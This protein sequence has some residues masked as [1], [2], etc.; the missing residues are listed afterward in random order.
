MAGAA[1]WPTS[2]TSDSTTQAPSQGGVRPPPLRTYSE[3]VASET[4]NTSDANGHFRR[5]STH[6]HLDLGSSLAGVATGAHTSKLTTV[7]ELRQ[8]PRQTRLGLGQPLSPPMTPQKDVLGGENDVQAATEEDPDILP[9][10]FSRIDYELDRARAI[11]QGLWSTVYYAQPV[12][13]TSSQP[14]QDVPSPPLSPQWTV[15]LPSVSLYAIKIA[16]RADAKHVFLREARTLTK[17]QRHSHADDHVVRFMGLDERVGW[18]VFEGVVGG[19]LDSLP[20]RLK[21]MTELERHLELRNVFP[22]IAADLISGMD[23]IHSA[24]VV[25]ADIKPAN[26]LFDVAEHDQRSLI[27]RAR[28]IDFSAAFTP[29]QDSSANAGGTWDYMAPE[30]LRIQKDLNTPTFASDI[31]SLG[32]TLLSLIVGGSPYTAA[33]GENLFMLREAIKSGDP[34]GFARMDAVV[35]KRMVACQ[36]FVDCCKMALQKDRA[37]RTTATVWKNWLAENLD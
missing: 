36:D 8:T 26:I 15:E 37:R 35:Q 30:Q 20:R 21:V 29:G 4:P 16:S 27:I 2:L 22:K 32:I 1:I 5:K 23:F 7:S 14:Q 18:L 31:W 25:H 6:P 33:C 28:Y 24:D 3:C 13:K 19:S 34:L 11:G 9:Y 17:I 10:D 12:V